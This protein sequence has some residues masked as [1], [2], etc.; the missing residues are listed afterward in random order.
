[1]CQEG[2]RF[3]HWRTALNSPS[4]PTWIQHEVG[5]VVASARLH[6]RR[7]QL[8]RGGG[9]GAPSRRDVPRVEDIAPP[10]G[11]ERGGHQLGHHAGHRTGRQ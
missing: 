1:M 5:Q 11:R 4:I 7:A 8:A 9:S 10:D 3:R 2:R 6:R